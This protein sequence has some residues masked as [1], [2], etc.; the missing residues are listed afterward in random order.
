M[1][2]KNG[3]YV[4]ETRANMK[5]G[6][7][8]VTLQHYFR[9]E[10][11]GGEHIRVCAKLIIPPGA[12]IGLHEHAGEDEVYIVLKGKGRVTDDGKTAEITV[13]DSV[14]TG[15]GTSHAVECVGDETLEILA[16]VVTY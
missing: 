12:G 1:I 4:Q 10:E 3:A 9:K 11:Y 8:K 14:L 5:G 7:G 16:L 2:K 6:P 13:G 15:K